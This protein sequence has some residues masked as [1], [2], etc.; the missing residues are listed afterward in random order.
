MSNWFQLVKNT[1]A[2]YGISDE[3]IYNFD[4]TEFQMRIIDTVK[5][6]TGSQRAK[7]ALVTQSENQ[8]WVT[9]VKAINISDWALLSIIIFVDKMHQAVWYEAISSQWIIAVSENEWIIDKI[10]LIWLQTV[11]NKHTKACTVEQY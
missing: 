11:F 5:V 4:K 8:E 10:G 7:K 9:V 6:V 3:D 2:K 1:Q